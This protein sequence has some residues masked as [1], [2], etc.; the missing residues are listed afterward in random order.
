MA[1]KGTECVIDLLQQQEQRRRTTAG[2]DVPIEYFTARVI[3]LEYHIEYL[4]TQIIPEVTG[5]K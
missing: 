3:S 5:S 4:S 2:R 1:N